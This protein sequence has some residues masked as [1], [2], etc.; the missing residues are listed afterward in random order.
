MDQDAPWITVF[1]QKSNK[2]S[3][4]NFGLRYV[5]GGVG[6]GA[7]LK[8]AYFS[9]QGAQVLTQFLFFKFMSSDAKMKSGQ[10]EM[11]LSPQTIAT[12]EDTLQQKVGPFIVANIKNINI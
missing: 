7:T 12:S 9:L 1:E 5:D 8:T 2:V 10:C 6:G 3:A 11:S 4:A